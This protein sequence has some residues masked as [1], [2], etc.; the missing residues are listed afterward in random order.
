A[1]I[2]NYQKSYVA[3]KIGE[4]S[5]TGL[6]HRLFKIFLKTFCPYATTLLKNFAF[7]TSRRFSPIVYCAHFPTALLSI[8]KTGMRT[9]P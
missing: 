7:I 8:P 4:K 1:F 3:E 9:I 5:L 6:L 2:D